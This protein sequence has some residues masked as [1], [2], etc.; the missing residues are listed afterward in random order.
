MSVISGADGGRPQ[1]GRWGVEE[2]DGTHAARVRRHSRNLRVRRRALARGLRHQH[3]LHVADEGREP[4]GL[5]G[6]RGG[7]SEAV[8]P[9]AGTD[10]RRPQARL[11]PHAR[12]RRQ[13]LFHRQARRDRRAFVPA[14]RRDHDRFHPAGLCRHDARG[15]PLGGRQPQQVRQGQAGEGQRRGQTGDQDRR[16]GEVEACRRQ[17]EIQIQV[18]VEILSK[19]EVS[20]GKDHR[21][22]WVVARPRHRGGA[23]QWQ[24]RGALLEAGVLGL[25]EVQGMDGR[26]Q[27]RRGHRGL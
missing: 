21:R 7:V 25:R 5:Q 15:R 11:Q 1:G 20:R 3:V 10:R 12:A 2:A 23:R 16:Q 19:A 6:R 9:H 14:P 22:C 4:Q 27:A 26:D 8:P 13:H 17:G 24:D 18:Q